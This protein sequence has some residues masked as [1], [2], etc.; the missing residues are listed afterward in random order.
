MALAI[1]ILAFALGSAVGLAALYSATRVFVMPRAIND[2]IARATFLTIRFVFE[3]VTG[4]AATYKRRDAIMA[5]YAPVGLLALL[6]VWLALVLVGFM[7]VFWGLGASTW[8]D[9]FNISGS[10]L[11]TLGF[12]GTSGLPMTL[13]AF[14][15]AAI[16]LVL[17]ALLIAYLPTIYSAFSRREAL[18]SLLETRAGS[19]PSPVTMYQ[20]FHRLKRQEKA[21]DLWD[22]W[23]HWFTDVDETHTS[24]AA[25]AFFR[26]PR[27]DRHW[28]TAAGAVLD[29]AALHVSTLDVPHDVQADL[30]IRAGYLA[31]RHIAELYFIP[32]D[33]DPAPDD[34]ISVTRAEF[35]AAC[36]EMA[37]YGIALKSDRDQAWRDFRGWR[38]NYD[39]PL[40]AL[41]HL[42]MAPE[43]PWVSDPPRMTWA[44][45]LHT[46]SRHKE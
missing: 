5:L 3:L 31:L 14:V 16:G 12:A 29:A 17:V 21:N 4:R 41:A 8:H 6:N 33:P 24:L 44:A 20:R 38:I 37:A 13:A 18:V 45:T 28:V 11:L 23:E 22:L 10:S 19:P 26:S 30:C 7:G 35:D 25:L 1:H 2:K 32:Y 36:D 40:L 9:A 42:T 43:A 39:T 15:E 34:P 46:K 27:S